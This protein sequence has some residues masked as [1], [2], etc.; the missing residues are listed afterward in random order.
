MNAEL[1]AS[2]L[3]L[4]D[5]LCLLDLA[6]R[7]IEAAS[8]AAQIPELDLDKLSPPLREP[9]ACFVTLHK[10]EQLRGCTGVLAP[11][12]PLALEVSRTA[13]QT[14]LYDPRFDPVSPE[15]VPELDIEIS[16]LTTPQRL[17][18]EIP[19]QLPRRLRPGIDGVTLMKGPYRATFLPQ[20][21]KR[22]PEPE[23]F[24]NLLCQKMGLPA[25]TWR[26]M[27]L[28]VEIYQ[29]EEFSEHNLGESV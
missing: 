23:M 29:V 8:L 21:W 9:K 15:E 2:Q 24:L 18:V 13:A 27:P 4:Q 19:S 11:R 1:S 16:I 6:R 3:S 22:V 17:H 25:S 12:S 28:D 20:V 10:Y 26:L 14:A 7:S 5:R